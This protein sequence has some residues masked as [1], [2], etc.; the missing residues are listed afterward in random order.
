MSGESGTIASFAPTYHCQVHG[1][2]PSRRR[3]SLNC[4]CTTASFKTLGRRLFVV[5]S[6]SS[7]NTSGRACTLSRRSRSCLCP[8]RSI[9]TTEPTQQRKSDILFSVDLRIYLIDDPL[10]VVAKCS[11]VLPG[12][13]TDESR[14]SMC[15]HSA[16]RACREFVSFLPS[17]ECDTTSLQVC[18]INY[19]REAHFC[20]LY[21]VSVLSALVCGRQAAEKTGY[22][23]VRI[24]FKVVLFAAVNR[25]RSTTL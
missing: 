21:L 9:S 8:P 5:F 18:C 15:V 17:I 11:K 16:T 23:S 25:Q 3:V 6:G 10:Q 20:N 24:Y 2:L 19:N 1:R 4:T 12:C 14:S 22:Q 7:P 13:T